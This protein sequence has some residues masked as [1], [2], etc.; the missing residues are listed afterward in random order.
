MYNIVCTI[1]FKNEKYKI[2]TIIASTFKNQF[3]SL[4]EDLLSNVLQFNLHNFVQQ[5]LF[6]WSINLSSYYN[7]ETSW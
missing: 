4:K 2:L 5:F 3:K 1:V 6:L 7:S